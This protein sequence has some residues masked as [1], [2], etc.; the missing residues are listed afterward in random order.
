VRG[1]R[2]GTIEK[3]EVFTAAMEPVKY[4]KVT[5]RWFLILGWT[6]KVCGKGIDFGIKALHFQVVSKKLLL[7]VSRAGYLRVTSATL[8]GHCRTLPGHRI[9]DRISPLRVEHC[10]VQEQ[11]EI[12]TS[13]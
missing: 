10:K 5:N 7:R 11:R 12:R 8:I 2:A 4:Q 1:V 13:G 9:L 6:K 3:G